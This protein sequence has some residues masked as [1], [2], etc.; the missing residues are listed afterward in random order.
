MFHRVEMDVH[1]GRK[2]Q[3]PESASSSACKQ[4]NRWLKKP[5]GSN[6]ASLPAS[7]RRWLASVSAW[8]AGTARHGGISFAFALAACD[9][10]SGSVRAP[11]AG[12]FFSASRS[13]V[14]RLT[15]N[16]FR[17]LLWRL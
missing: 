17:T 7:V 4:G 16:A 9:A 10:P 2:V 12:A 13:G 3:M 1:V 8:Q 6:L 15:P 11:P 14:Q 5:V